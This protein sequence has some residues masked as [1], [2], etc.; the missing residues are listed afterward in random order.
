[1]TYTLPTYAE[2][3]ARFPKFDCVDE[4]TFDVIVAEAPLYVGQ[5]WLS[6]ADYTLGAML[7]TAHTM[8]CDGLIDSVEGELAELGDFTSFKS[9]RLSITRSRTEAPKSETDRWLEKTQHGQRFKQL[10]A[11]NVPSVMVV[12]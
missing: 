6:Q 7:I 8:T 2:F 3:I 12:A 5:C 10:R 9:G 11:R 4:A 1:M